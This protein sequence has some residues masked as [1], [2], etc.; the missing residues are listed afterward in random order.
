MFV[1]ARQPIFGGRV[2]RLETEQL[3]CDVTMRAVRVNTGWLVVS[4]W[5]RWRLAVR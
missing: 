1:D 3:P 2:I 4:F 5:E